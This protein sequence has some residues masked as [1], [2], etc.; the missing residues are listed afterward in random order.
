MAQ[1]YIN[2]FTSLGILISGEIVE[3][4]LRISFSEFKFIMLLIKVTVY[5]KKSLSFLIIF[6][7]F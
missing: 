5:K 4:E 3:I 7:H 2:I 6:V 1:L